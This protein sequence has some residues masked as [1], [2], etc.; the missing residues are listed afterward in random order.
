MR[1]NKNAIYALWS[2]SVEA[3]KTRK[4]IAVCLSQ[5]QVICVCVLICFYQ[6]QGFVLVNLCLLGVNPILEFSYTRQRADCSP[7]SC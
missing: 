5:E 4:S 3:V 6:M 1:Q 2:Q 7:I